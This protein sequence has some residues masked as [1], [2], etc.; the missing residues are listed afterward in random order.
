MHLTLCDRL[1]SEEGSRQRP[2]FELYAHDHHFLSKARL[3]TARGHA[4]GISEGTPPSPAP[5]FHLNAPPG[6]TNDFFT[7]FLTSL[8]KGGWV[9]SNQFTSA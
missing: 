1:Y 9:R 8:G 4:D 7:F 5:D 2:E 6:L 3:G